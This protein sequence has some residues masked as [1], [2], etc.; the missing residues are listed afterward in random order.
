MRIL[1]VTRETAGDRRFGLGKS[2]LPVC[3]ALTAA[4][5]EVRYVTQEDLGPRARAAMPRLTA[6]LRLGAGAGFGDAGR[7]LASAWAERINV[8]RLAAKMART[9]G[10]TVVHL[11]DPWIAW[12]FR[13]AS[14][15]HRSPHSLRWGFTEHG[16]GSYADATHEEGVRYTP[17]LMSWL[18][19]LEARVAAAAD[20]VVCP[21]AAG[22]L[23]LARD[24]A[25]PNPPPSWHVV[26]HARPVLNLSER[27]P[28]RQ[29]LGLAE[30]TPL[31]LAVGRINPVKRLD[32]IVA[33]CVRLS[34][35]LRLVL[36]AGPG[37]AAALR[38]M[39]A[40]APQLQLDIL[41]ADDV[42]P[43]L[44]AADVYVSAARNESFGLANLEGL[45]AGLP[46]VCT[47]VGGVPE[48]MG[49]AAWL[50]AAGD[51][52]LDAD[53]GTAIAALL[54]DAPRRRAY[55]AAALARGTSWPTAEQIG[56]RYEA[57]YRG[58]A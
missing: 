35:P 28:A 39:A 41:L 19:R 1:H 44:S 9:E 23:Q 57:V 22:R 13:Q 4:G 53:L 43:Y 34:R 37:D 55:A 31:V 46:C 38:A 42:G 24:L 32:R 49:N 18:R 5:H 48:V 8:G 17:R 27:L 14:L 11:H 56:S 40:A 54:G 6:A 58:V 16:F 33:A 51:D 47:A 36:L 21:T 3:Q 30:D 29:A 52:G 10:Y 20:W 25:R 26:P 7:D 15:L 50:L 12:G 2:L 45:V